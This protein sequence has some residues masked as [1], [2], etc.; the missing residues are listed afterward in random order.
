MGKGAEEM[1]PKICKSCSQEYS[2][3]ENFNWSCRTHASTWGGEVWWCCGKSDKNQAGCKFEKHASR[4]DEAFNKT[5][6]ELDAN[7]KLARCLC[8][9]Q[10]G[11][12]T[13]MCTKD[14]N[15]KTNSNDIDADE[16]RILEC[17]NSRKFHI[18]SVVGT[19]H[20]LKKAVMQPITNETTISVTT[21]TDP[22]APG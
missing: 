2:D 10:I 17:G 18:D 7:R 21:I 6:E 5:D 16:L 1:A 3:K 19:T 22:P 9:K 4:E 20:L 13:D 15:L 12:T 11:H 14:P 8:C